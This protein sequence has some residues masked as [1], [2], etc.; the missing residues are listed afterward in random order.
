M[1]SHSLQTFDSE[2]E[3]ARTTAS[4]GT[5]RGKYS[6]SATPAW[7]NIGNTMSCGIQGAFGH[8]QSGRIQSGT[9]KRTDAGRPFATR[10]LQTNASQLRARSTDASL[11]VMVCLAGRWN[12]GPA[13][14][15]DA[16]P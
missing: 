3:G 5:P 8:T 15:S 11:T 2:A 9:H 6:I 7:D 13:R 1:S 14:A 16:T 10:D 4:K 12:V